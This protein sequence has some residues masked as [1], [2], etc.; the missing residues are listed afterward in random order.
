MVVL[1]G[2]VVSYERGTPVGVLYVWGEEGSEDLGDGGNFLPLPGFKV[3]G[4]YCKD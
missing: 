2:E 4:V 1:G 3:W